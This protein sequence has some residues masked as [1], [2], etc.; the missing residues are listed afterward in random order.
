MATEMKQLPFSKEEISRFSK[1]RGEPD[2]LHDLRLRALA[3]FEELPMPETEKTRIKG[4]NFTD[5]K[6][7][8][9]SEKL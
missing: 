1:D 8:V 7:D 3:G 5:F 2:W 6:Y 9:Q 4:W